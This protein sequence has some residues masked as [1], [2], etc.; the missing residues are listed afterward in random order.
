MGQSGFLPGLFIVRARESGSHLPS[1]LSQKHWN[2]LM[3]HEPTEG[4]MW[5]KGERLAALVA[6]ERT[7]LL[8]D[9]LEPLQSDNTIEEGAIKDPV[10]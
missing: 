6:K 9:G 5:D 8:L 4:S 1:F 10:Y 2:G 7:L 3:I